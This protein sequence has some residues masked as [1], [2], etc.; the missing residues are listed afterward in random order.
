M[1]LAPPKLTPVLCF[2]ALTFLS[3]HVRAVEPEEGPT[4]QAS[5]AEPTGINLLT[6]LNVAGFGLLGPTLSVEGGRS[7]TG[8]LRLHALSLGIL[9]H[10][11]I[12]NAASGESLNLGSG[13]VGVGLRWYPTSTLGNGGFYGGLQF[14]Y[15]RISTTNASQ[16]ELNIPVYVPGVDTGYRWMFGKLMLGVGAELGLSIPSGGTCTAPAGLICSVTP[17]DP[18]FYGQAVLDVGYLLR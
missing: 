2:T 14:E 3:L 4:E 8:M 18:Q 13:G 16:S 11:I 15:L 17:D 1:L 5:P 6:S 9:S 10:E 7:V 12:P